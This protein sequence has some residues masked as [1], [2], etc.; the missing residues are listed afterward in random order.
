MKLTQK[1]L[2]ELLHYDP[3]TG[4]FTWKVRPANC[5]QIGDVAG[6]TDFYGYCRIRVLGKICKAHRLAFLYM[7]GYM[8]ENCVDHINRI[9]NDNRWCNLREV[10]RSCNAKNREFCPSDTTG[11][12]GV[13]FYKTMGKWGARIHVNRSRV[14][15]GC[16]ETKTDAAKARWEAEVKY[17]FPKCSTDSSAYLYLKELGMIC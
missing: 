15:L 5:L 6:G 12:V 16:F 2:K 7:E 13:R 9:R 8:P 3:D 14:Y 10:S 4:I 17:G 11:V 1:R